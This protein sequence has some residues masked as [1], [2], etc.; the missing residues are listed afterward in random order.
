MRL[1][2]ELITFEVEL[3]LAVIVELLDHP[4]GQDT[5]TRLLFNSCREFLIILCLLN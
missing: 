4:V 1:S 2:S 3:F 5:G